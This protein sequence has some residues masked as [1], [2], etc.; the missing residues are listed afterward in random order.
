MGLSVPMARSVLV[1]HSVTDAEAA[2]VGEADVD[3]AAGSI[4]VSFV[5]CC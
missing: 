4:A 2:G 3:A 1:A 5:S